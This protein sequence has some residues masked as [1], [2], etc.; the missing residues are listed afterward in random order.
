MYP[1]E[2]HRR[3]PRVSV[4]VN[5]L[6]GLSGQWQL[7]GGRGALSTAKSSIPEEPLQRVEEGNPA[8]AGGRSA[9]G[10]S[11]TPGS[12]LSCHLPLPNSGTRVQDLG[13]G[14]QG[15][16]SSVVRGQSMSIGALVQ[17]KSGG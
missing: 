9:R 15:P 12:C 11:A 17:L 4:G 16:V 6:K 2:N 10:R 14:V 8:N 13:S 1:N 5:S 3:G 7:A